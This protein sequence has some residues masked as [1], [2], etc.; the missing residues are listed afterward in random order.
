MQFLVS[1]AG[2][3]GAG[4]AGAG[5]GVGVTPIRPEGQLHPRGLYEDL[6]T[7]DVLIF[8]GYHPEPVRVTLPAWAR[9]PGAFQAMQR[10][11]AEHHPAVRRQA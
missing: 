10:W 11:L 7:G 5:G 1:D 6:D 3:L 2:R 8:D 9:E 4:A